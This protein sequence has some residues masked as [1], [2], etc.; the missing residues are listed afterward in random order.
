MS[1]DRTWPRQNGMTDRRKKRTSS[2]LIF[3]SKRNSFKSIFAFNVSICSEIMLVI[4]SLS[5]KMF[6][7]HC[8]FRSATWSKCGRFCLEE[9]NF[10]G[11]I[12]VHPAVTGLV[13]KL[14]PYIQALACPARTD[15]KPREVTKPSSLA[16][17]SSY[18]SCA[19]CR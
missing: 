9:G 10:H 18:S 16:R 11:Q 13:K 2:S 8:Q 1:C 19:V 5:P 17:P 14:L 7:C 15:R 3:V 4:L 12:L 6:C